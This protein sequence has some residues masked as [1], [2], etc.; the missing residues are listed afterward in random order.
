MAS[1]V[2]MILPPAVVSDHFG[3]GCSVTDGLAHDAGQA[4]DE[5]VAVSQRLGVAD[6]SPY[7]TTPRPRQRQ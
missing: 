3:G 4:A 5:G 7:V 1:N 6:D 2:N